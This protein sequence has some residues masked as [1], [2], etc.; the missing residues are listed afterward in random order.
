MQALQ[1]NFLKY[2]CLLHC[3]PCDSQLLYL[4]TCPLVLFSPGNVSALLFTLG[5]LWVL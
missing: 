5:H 4:S 3:V 1:Q 2:V